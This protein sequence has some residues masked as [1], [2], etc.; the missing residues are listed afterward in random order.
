MHPR[1]IAL[2]ALAAVP[3]LLPVAP[4]RADCVDGTRTPT[5]AESE[6]ARSARAALAA[7]LP[8]GGPQLERPRAAS[9]SD[10]PTSEG[11]LC[12]GT[13]VGAFE[14]EA[15]GSY[16]RTFTPAEA[17]LRDAKRRALEQEVARL[18]VLP[19]ELKAQ[20]DEYWRQA[21]AV[22][23][24]V[25]TRSRKDPPFTPEQQAVVDQ[26]S[27]EGRALETKARNVQRDWERSLESKTLPLQQQAHALENSPKEFA[28]RLLINSP[29]WRYRD[30]GVAYVKTHG[31]MLKG[32]GGGGGLTVKQVGII[33][34][35]PEGATRDAIVAALDVAYLE[36]L[37]GRPL[38]SREASIARAAQVASVQ[39]PLEAS[40][41][42]VAANG[43]AG[44]PTPVA[45]AG[46][47]TAGAAAGAT[48]AAATTAAPTTVAAPAKPTCPPQTAS[49]EQAGAEVGGAVVGGGYGRE[50]GRTIGGALGA[51]GS[52]G[53][54]KKDEPQP[55]CP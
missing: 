7:A 19:P 10:V 35:G 30:A 20:E 29:E 18:R 47:A 38:P 22:Y 27:A 26:R 2:A 42:A 25:P 12:G 5:P 37:V 8:A 44:D 21:K 51:L 13:K 52:L 15:N 14:V 54:K 33:V 34:R 4:A 55:D 49:A 46:A 11:S 17:R 48:A 24:T 23:A 39:V 31:P 6:F 53:R 50:M 45:G 43:G 16:V 41:P 32:P 40:G 3:L 36:G 28:V 9:P 1:P